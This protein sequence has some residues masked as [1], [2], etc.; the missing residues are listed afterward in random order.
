MKKEYESRISKLEQEN[1]Q[2]RHYIELIANQL[3][4]FQIKNNFKEQPIRSIF[5]YDDDLLTSTH[6][7]NDLDY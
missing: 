5:E 2:L 4:T 6:L 7:L 1:K 3:P